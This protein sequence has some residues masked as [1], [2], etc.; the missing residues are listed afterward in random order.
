MKKKYRVVFLLFAVL[1]SLLLVSCSGNS[2]NDEIPAL[3]IADEE[4]AKL[5]E[6][7]PITKCPL[8]GVA[9]IVTVENTGSESYYSYDIT[10][11]SWFEYEE[12]IAYYGSKFPD[13]ITKDFG[14]VYSYFVVPSKL[15]TETEKYYMLNY[16]IY[17][18]MTLGSKGMCTVVV[19]ISEY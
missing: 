7:F 1:A 15:S 2:A 3:E 9:E 17:S 19:S 4:F 16:N 8:Y 18:D 13:A 10:F 14:I 5:P 6:G 12:I 11:N